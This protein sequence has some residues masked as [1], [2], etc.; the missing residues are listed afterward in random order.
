LIVLDMAEETD[1]GVDKTKKKADRGVTLSMGGVTPRSALPST[2]FFIAPPKSLIA[3]RT[4]H[5][6]LS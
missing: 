5:M 6:L 3:H 1:R 2:P 4:Y